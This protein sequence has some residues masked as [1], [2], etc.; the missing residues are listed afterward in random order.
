[1]GKLGLAGTSM[2][3]A[4]PGGV[5]FYVLLMAVV[6]HFERMP[7]MLKASTLLMLTISLV[8]ALFPLYILIMFRRDK[9]VLAKKA[10]AGAG[11]AAAGAG[12]EVFTDD[13]VDEG[14]LE[15]P[16][17]E[18][19]DEWT[20]EED[21]EE[22]SA[23]AEEF[24]HSDLDENQ[25]PTAEFDV[26]EQVAGADEFGQTVQDF[27]QSDDED[28]FSA[29]GDLEDDL[30][31]G[32]EDSRQTMEFNAADNDEFGQTMP[33]FGGDQQEDFTVADDFDDEFTFD[34]FGDDD[35]QPKKKK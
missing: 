6:N 22:M 10:T 25:F 23:S 27:S 17:S 20:A 12:N 19:A 21:V 28:I 31:S 3:S 5:L 33:A 18:A 16:H 8:M 1:M 2:A 32:D 35:D 29:S 9:V 14:Q 26:D 24:E 34:D 4:I 13:L 11:I 7:T 15:D 30:I